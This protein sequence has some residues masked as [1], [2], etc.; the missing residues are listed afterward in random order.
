MK[1]ISTSVEACAL[2]RNWDLKKICLRAIDLKKLFSINLLN[3]TI[4][5]SAVLE[6]C[7]SEGWGQAD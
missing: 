7:D 2:T 4:K 1:E 6:L 5:L 3:K